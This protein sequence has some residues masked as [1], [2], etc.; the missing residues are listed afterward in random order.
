[1]LSR[2]FSLVSLA[3]EKSKFLKSGPTK[4]IAAQI[5]EVV[6]AEANAVHRVP[7]ARRGK[8]AKVQQLVVAAGP[9]KRIAD[10]IRPLKEFIAVVEIFKRVQVIRLSAG[11]A[12]QAVDRPAIGEQLRRG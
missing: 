4:R 12:Q 6:T 8:C 9:G 7:V 1:M 3:S 11:E 5:A 10:D 2:S